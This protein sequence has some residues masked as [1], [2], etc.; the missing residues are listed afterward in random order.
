[1]KTKKLVFDRLDR[2][3]QV[4]DGK[5]LISDLPRLPDGQMAIN[6]FQELLPNVGSS[7]KQKVFDKPTGKIHTVQRLL[8]RFEELNEQTTKKKVEPHPTAC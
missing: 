4:T 5:Q 3:S 2:V 7:R 1:M 8:E 6:H